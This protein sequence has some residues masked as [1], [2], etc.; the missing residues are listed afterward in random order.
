MSRPSP[1]RHMRV[2]SRAMSMSEACSCAESKQMRWRGT[3]H[4]HGCKM[5]GWTRKSLCAMQAVYCVVFGFRKKVRDAIFHWQKGG[6]RASYAL[7][8]SCKFWMHFI[9]SPM[10]KGRWQAHCVMRRA[11]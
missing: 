7:R 2:R 3:C 5:E 11:C 10:T 4:T 9:F 1:C 8:R 6:R